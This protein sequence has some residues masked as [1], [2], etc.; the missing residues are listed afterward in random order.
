MTPRKPDFALGGDGDLEIN[1]SAKKD[2]AEA[3]NSPPS[4]A[5]VQEELEAIIE[6]L[7][8]DE[9]EL[10]QSIALYEKGAK[11]LAQ[12]QQVLTDAEQRVRLLS[13]SELN[14]EDD[15]DPDDI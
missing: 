3:E 12:A 7:E 4:L 2:N 8:D 11:L 1:V 5:V 9:T 13:E 15:A 6:H 14:G 10:E